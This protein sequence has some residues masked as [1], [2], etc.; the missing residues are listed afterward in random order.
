MALGFVTPHL[1]QEDHELDEIGARLLPERLLAAAIEI[2]HER[3]DAERQRVGVEVVVERVVSV[4]RGEADFDV[5]GGTFEVGQHRFHLL[6]EV[7]L[8]FQYQ[9]T[10]FARRVLG[11][12]RETRLH[13]ELAEV[14]LV[15]EQLTLKERV[16]D[17]IAV[18]TNG[19]FI[20]QKHGVTRMPLGWRVNRP[21]GQ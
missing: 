8:C 4:A 7:P 5:V 20:A 12:E 17:W 21:E 1:V 9:A 18:V 10:E 13:Q 6:V 15:G 19:K 2:G 14:G 16:F 3:G 11:L